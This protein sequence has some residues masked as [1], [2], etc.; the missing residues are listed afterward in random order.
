[1][2]V[3]HLLQSLSA[4]PG[5]APGFVH[6]E[7]IP[8]RDAEYGT[9][10]RDLPLPIRQYLDSRHITLYSH[11]CEAIEAF[12]AGES[13][14]LTTSTAS[15]KTLAY[16][17]PVF[18]GIF[19]HPESSFL[20]LYPTK[21]LT[22]DQLRTFLSL[23]EQVGITASTAVYDGDTETG[24]RPRIRQSVRILLSNPHE[25]HHILSWHH[26]WSRFFS[27][28][29]GVVIDEAHRYRG[30]FGSHV[31]L[32]LRRLRRISRH[33]G[34]D[35]RF[36][37]STATLANPSQF[38]SRLCGIP[39]RE[40]GR[41]G[42]PH[43]PRTC[44]FYNPYQ[45]WPLA[46]SVHRDTSILLAKCMDHGL[47]TICFTGS[48]K[49]A[50]LVALRAGDMSSRGKRDAAP[51]IAA[52]RAGYLPE[53][54]RQIEEG[55]RTGTLR[56]VVSTNALEVGIDIGSLEGVILSGFPGT[57]MAAWQQ[58]G[59]AG[60][61]SRESLALMVAYANPLDQYFMH[62]PASFF[63]ASHEHAIID[64]EN[65][66]ILSGQILCAGAE[67]PL[68]CDRD[69]E[70]FG[71]SLPTVI[72]A[73]ARESLLGKTRRG[74]IYSG[75]RRASDLVGM[76]GISRETFRVLS[77]GR[78]IETMDRSQAFRE[79]H[80]GAIL[81]HQ[82]EQYRVDSC[83]LEGKTIHVTPVDVEYYTRPLKSV[84][85]TIKGIRDQR[86]LPGAHLS[87]GDVEVTEQYTG[88]KLLKS[89]TIIGIEPL[90]LPPMQ[91]ATRA[92]WIGVPPPVAEVV[93]L[94][95]G[96]LAG[97]LHGME[98]A[99]IA[100]M[101]FHVLCDRW[102]IGGLS[103]PCGGDQ[104]DPTVFVYDGYEGGIG[105]AEKG[106]EI[107]EDLLG[108]ARTLVGEC[109]CEAGCPSCVLSPKCGNDNQP[110][111]KDAALQLISLVSG[112]E[113]VKK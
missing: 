52:Y 54:R 77:Q 36:F 61:S 49:T 70:Y 63:G 11:Q 72:A 109:E 9:L 112:A 67:L 111:D 3:A 108:T 2:G 40:I 74:W 101:P 99:M 58:V 8:A 44:V 98:H 50:E 102:D 106:Y 39:C 66:Y 38:A 69:S 20:L 28:L 59:R 88:Y 65:P 91:F 19:E 10:G 46:R 97:G 25:L 13:V 60:R 42:S 48:R 110:M 57:M 35:P 92:L 81:L 68:D 76:D 83:D 12:R 82:G 37:L 24:R 107:C 56:G 94:R 113:T 6:T 96:D 33:Y 105:L 100:V 86:P 32:L 75:S 27:G 104:G 71:P 53:E 62:H 26:Q 73:H 89:E 87:Y 85:I 14:I 34:S 80:H 21:A 84:H 55:L 51:G 45:A 18:E 1:M 23:E 7:E 78:V 90:D 41:D 17:L 93:N 22:H 29:G 4:D 64:L 47:Q 5:L 95:G 79:A 15:G 16:A 43:G 103:V 30:V 31:A